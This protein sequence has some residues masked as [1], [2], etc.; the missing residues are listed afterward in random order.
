MCL[1]HG[2]ESFLIGSCYKDLIWWV[3]CQFYPYEDMDTPKILQELGVHHQGLYRDFP[4][5][6]RKHSR[7]PY[8]ILQASQFHPLARFPTLH[9]YMNVEIQVS[10]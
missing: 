10:H 9:L 5:R 4:S 8:P 6:Y 2:I 1:R 7:K 3:V